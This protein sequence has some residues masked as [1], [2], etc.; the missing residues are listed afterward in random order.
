MR[1][2]H[3]KPKPEPR[4]ILRRTEITIDREWLSLELRLDPEPTKPPND[5]HPPIKSKDQA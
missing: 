3:R 1:L 4:E 2:F 5:Q